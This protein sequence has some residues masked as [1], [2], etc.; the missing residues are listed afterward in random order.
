MEA[1]GGSSAQGLEEAV[2][3]PH[4]CRAQGGAARVGLPSIA[5]DAPKELWGA[6]LSKA[7]QGPLYINT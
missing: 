5:R 1:E 4:R 7:A 6:E 2:P 3:V